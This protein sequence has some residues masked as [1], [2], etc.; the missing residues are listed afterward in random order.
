[1][2]CGVWGPAPLWLQ[3]HIIPLSE[4]LHLAALPLHVH[5][6]LLSFAFYQALHSVVSPAVSRR[7]FPRRYAAFDART[8]LN[9]DIH[10]VALVQ[11]VLISVLSLYVEFAEPARAAMTTPVDRLYGY[12]P[13]AGTVGAMATGYFLWDTIVC[14]R[15]FRI[16]GPGM[17]AHALS[18]LAVYCAGFRP[19]LNYYSSTFLLYELSSPFLNVHW[20]C[21]K[22][23]RTGSSL[24]WYN[25]MLLLASFFGARLVWGTYHSLRFNVDVWNAWSRKQEYLPTGPS[26]RTSASTSLDLTWPNVRAGGVPTWLYL[27]FFLSNL[28]LNSLNWYWFRKM[29]TAV[30]KRFKP[31]KRVDEGREKDNVVDDAAGHLLAHSEVGGAAMIAEKAGEEPAA[32]RRGRPA[33]RV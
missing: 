24:Q 33:T 3:G 9:W 8:R 6:V 11:A 18:A 32:R 17:L 12:T 13:G 22:L 16:F 1:M 31:A 23:G 26:V 25:G 29:V 7:L 21:D 15:H 30:M 20:F 2:L 5:H 14:V 28:T 10:V 19:F 4:R 27:T